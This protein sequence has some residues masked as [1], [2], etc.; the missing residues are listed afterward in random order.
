MPKEHIHIL[1]LPE[2][3]IGVEVFSMSEIDPLIDLIEEVSIPHR[4][5]HYTCFFL[6]EGNLNFNIDFQEIE[7]SSPSLL[8]SSPGQVHQPGLGDVPAGWL[9]AFDAKLID[10]NARTVIE[11]SFTK[12]VILRL[13]DIEKKWFNHIFQL[14]YSSLKEK[15]SETFQHQ[16][17]QTLINSFFYKVVSIFQQQ[18]DKRIQ[19][20]SS[21]SVEI[22]KTFNQLVQ[23]HYLE[24][25]R[26]ADFA[27]KMNITVSYLNDTI[28]AVTGFSST[29]FI[30]QEIFREAQRLLFYTNKSIK[31]IAFQLGYE[32]YKYFIRLFS[33]IIGMSPS[34]FRNSQQSASVITDT[35]IPT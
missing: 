23:N 24:L 8:V 1:H 35:D 7:I 17:I 12:I 18:E 32:D 29:Y 5:D 13:H 19:E 30:Q 15:K 16:L 34:N 6:E 10:E 20:Y 14:L 3:H 25:K 9:I 28:K 26:P 2:R 33:K 11:Q 27:S 4:H 31:E 21:R 22:V